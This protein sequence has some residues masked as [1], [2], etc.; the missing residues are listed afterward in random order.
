MLRTCPPGTLRIDRYPRNATG[1]DPRVKAKTS[2]TSCL[3]TARDRDNK[4]DL[5]YRSWHFCE[6]LQCQYVRPYLIVD[7][8]NP[9]LDA[10]PYSRPN[11][12]YVA[13]MLDMNTW[14]WVGIEPTGELP[15]PRSG[16]QVRDYGTI[17]ET[18][19]PLVLVRFCRRT[20]RTCFRNV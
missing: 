2:Q 15:E 14:E 4:L 3:V 12:T 20:L 1:K 7:V 5:D 17:A 8:A 16:H 13:Q 18:L 9:R 11:C 10:L 19:R 6:P